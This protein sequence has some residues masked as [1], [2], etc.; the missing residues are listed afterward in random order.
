MVLESDGSYV[1]GNRVTRRP[2]PWLPHRPSY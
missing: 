2:L 1:G